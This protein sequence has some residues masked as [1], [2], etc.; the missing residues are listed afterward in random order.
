M[1]RNH[2]LVVLSLLFRQLI[3]RW[4]QFS[5]FLK[6]Q[7]A[8]LF[9]LIFMILAS[10]TYSFLV[11]EQAS[12][13]IQL[14]AGV[15][16]LFNI[17]RILTLPLLIRYSFPA[18]AAWQLLY[19]IDFK[20]KT[21]WAVFWYL[22]M[23]FDSAYI[24]LFLCLLAGWLFSSPVVGSIF[25]IGFVMYQQI[26]FFFLYRLVIMSKTI[27]DYST[28][29]FILFFFFLLSAALDYFAYPL[30]GVLLLLIPL[31]LLL[32]LKWPPVYN[33]AAWPMRGGNKFSEK[34]KLN[35]QA[36]AKG[37]R[38]RP[39]SAYFRKEWFSAWRNPALLWL[40][41]IYLSAGVMASFLLR[42]SA[43][44]D[45]AMWMVIGG[46]IFFWL[47]YSHFFNPK[48]YYS[49]PLYF[50]QTHPLTFRMV[51]TT[52][53][54]N[55][56]FPGLILWIFYCLPM[57]VTLP[58]AEIWQPASA[59]F[60]IIM[61]IVLLMLNFRLMF[62]DNPRLAGIAYHFSILFLA[63]IVINDLLVGPAIALGLNV[64]FFMRNRQY[65][66]RAL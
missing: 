39:F 32:R 28:G 17:S 37:R 16:A 34:Q 22:F 50:R 66:R 40:R 27:T 1:A 42:F 7:S 54:V 38:L 20:P 33:L 6:F 18:Q 25:F 26:L 61:L 41:G 53:L 57:L 11:A 21:D 44:E 12:F 4:R 31:F 60:L 24:L 19:K 13:Q 14:M 5:I 49:D 46:V 35:P 15:L 51:W 36:F 64:Y 58:F 3:S 63:I 10:R 43:K 8:I 59:L 48:Y 9:L 62:Y 29:F 52:R 30:S 45:P 65:F 47:H 56:L 2:N 23:I 55:E